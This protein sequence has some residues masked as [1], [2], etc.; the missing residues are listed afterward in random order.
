MARPS[1]MTRLLRG[2]IT[3]PL[4]VLVVVFAISNRQTVLVELW[5]LPDALEMPV[6]LMGLVA[7]FVGFLLGGTVAW[8]AAGTARRRAR[9]AERDANDLRRDLQSARRHAA[10]EGGQ[11]RLPG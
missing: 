4:T 11:A 6:Y 2:A 8:F 10:P 1:A 3:V 9:L 5:P 7:V